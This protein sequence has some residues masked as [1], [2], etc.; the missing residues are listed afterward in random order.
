VYNEIMADMTKLHQ[1]K[2]AIGRAARYGKGPAMKTAA[3]RRRDLHLITEPPTKADDQEARQIAEA[4]L[5]LQTL[6]DDFEAEV[7]SGMPDLDRV[8]QL[9]VEMAA[10]RKSVQAYVRANA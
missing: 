6:R 8:T 7:M 2:L 3:D 5:E 9:I 4:V 1:P 10:A